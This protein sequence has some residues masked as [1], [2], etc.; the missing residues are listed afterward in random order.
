MK[1]YKQQGGHWEKISREEGTLATFE[2]PENT[3][4]KRIVDDIIIA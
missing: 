1:V 2:E 3:I 4:L